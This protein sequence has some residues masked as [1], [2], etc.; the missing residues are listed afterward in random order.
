MKLI[1]LLLF[2]CLLSGILLSQNIAITDNHANILN[3]SVYNVSGSMQDPTIYA[4]V[5]VTNNKSTSISL[6]C[7]KIIIYAVPGSDNAFCWA[8]NCYPTT[9]FVSSNPETIA[10]GAT[11]TDFTGE[12][13]PQLNFG[14]DSIM[15][16][17]FTIPAG[18]SAEFT[19]VYDIP[20]GINNLRYKNNLFSV[21]PNPANNYL[22]VNNENRSTTKQVVYIYNC[23]GSVVKK[24]NADSFNTLLNISNLQS[25]FYFCSLYINDKKVSS[26]KLVINR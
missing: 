8:G 13:Y 17:F 4:F 10:A 15:Y 25:G 16:R 11:V 12:Y 21:N 5:N 24:I 7:K 14:A 6:W 1:Y 2:N 23:L 9:Q 3:N 26:K 20:A 19:V 18:D 22:V